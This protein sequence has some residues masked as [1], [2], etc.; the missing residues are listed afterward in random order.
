MNLFYSINTDTFVPLSHDNA[1]LFN[2]YDKLA[3]FLSLHLEK[4]H[5]YMLAKPIKS[6]FDINWFSPYH[7]LVPIEL[8][9]AKENAQRAYWEFY[10]ALESKILELSQQDNDNTRD[11]VSL[12]TKV[13]SPE[14]NLLFTNGL[15]I[16]II[17]GWKFES[18]Q[19]GRR[20]LLQNSLSV[21]EEALEQNSLDN[22]QNVD[23]VKIAAGPHQELSREEP[24]QPVENDFWSDRI[25]LPPMDQ[26]TVEMEAPRVR[27]GERRSFLDF[28]K[29]FASRYWWLLIIL[30]VLIA[31]VFMYKS[32]IT[33]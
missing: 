6:N 33:Y 27:T 23:Q 8:S 1:Y 21:D 20:D 11:W 3:N 30:L 16:N 10:T 14:N 25:E 22:Q 19:I 15:D 29:Y 7:N 13:F 12:L 17:W 24:A 32:I 4:K 2:H 9:N 31:I 26:N 5:R 28:L 18:N